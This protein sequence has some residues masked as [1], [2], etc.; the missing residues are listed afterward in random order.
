VR[1]GYIAKPIMEDRRLRVDT[2]RKTLGHGERD[3]VLVAGW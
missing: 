1:C 2:S 3:H